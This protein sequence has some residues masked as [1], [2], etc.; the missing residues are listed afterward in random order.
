MRQQREARLKLGRQKVCIL[1]FVLKTGL[2]YQQLQKTSMLGPL[3]CVVYSLVSFHCLLGLRKRL[4]CL[5]CST[6][7]R[8]SSNGKSAMFMHFSNSYRSNL[9]A[10]LR[11]LTNISR[12]SVKYSKPL[13]SQSA[14]STVVISLLRKGLALQA[15][16][17][18]ISLMQKQIV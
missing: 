18:S 6:R 2:L 10:D 13:R 1:V 16:V 15:K 5:Q 3:L 8:P 4:T 14:S 12:R 17:C 9:T 7:A 11:M